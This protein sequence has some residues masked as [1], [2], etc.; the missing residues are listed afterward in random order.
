MKNC[1]NFDIQKIIFAPAVG[2]L[3]MMIQLFSPQNASGQ[4]PRSEI[5]EKYT[6]NLSDLYESD[7]AWREHKDDLVGQF[8]Q[9]TAFQGKLS[10]SAEDLYAFL[11]YQSSLSREGARLFN[12]AGLKSDEDTRISEYR[13]MRQELMQAYNTYSSMAAFAEP[14]ILAMDWSRIEEFMAEKPGLEVYRMYLSNL[15]RM[16]MHTLS[17][18]EE[19]ILAQ[20]GLMAGNSASVYQT[21]TDAEM[22]YPS[23]TLSDGKEVRLDKAAYSMYRAL[24]NR[25]DREKVFHAFWGTYADFNGTFGEMLYG[26]VKRDVFYARARNYGSSLESALDYNKIPVEVYYS[27]IENVNNNLETF[28]RYLRIKK[29]MLGVD[30]LKYSDIYATAIEGVD[31]KYT[32]EEARGIL[33]E[34]VQSL[35]E[36]YVSV[37]RKALDERWI[38]VYPSTGKTSGAY[39]SGNAYDVHPYILLNYNGLYEDLSTLAHEMGHTMHSYFSNANQPFPLADYSIFVAEVASTF[40]EAMLMNNMMDRIKDDRTRLS[41]LMTY[42]DGF[43]G[44]IVRQTQ[45]AEF[46]LK[47]HETVEKGTPLT[48]ELLRE[49]YGEILKKY[50]G[51]DQGICLIDDDVTM[52]WA[53]IPHFYNNFYVYQYATSYTA[54]LALAEGV[55][56]REEG[57]RERYLEF[58][59]AGGSRYPIDVLKTAGVDMTT[60]LPFEKTME[61]INR[62]MDQIEGILDNQ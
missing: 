26:N 25:D 36:E 48:G 17:A 44:S 18:P 2:V 22:P 53:Y 3:F 43:K 50:Y 12:Y 10:N 37:V 55:L 51:H 13:S 46:E 42:L 28:H 19:K 6:W 16:K 49:I 54:S 34:V 9:V 11:E 23:V 60:A 47:I 40:N 30:T 57:A 56:N 5:P 58:L 41:L 61:A 27:L 59:S 62:I 15:F 20:A 52:E 1:L 7:Q 45:F 4:K 39:S 8:E 24:E 29:R 14:E 35:G 31:L 21:F 32:Y 33:L 38:D